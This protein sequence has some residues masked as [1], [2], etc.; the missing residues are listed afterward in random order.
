MLYELESRGLLSG[1]T[2]LIDI[3]KLGLDYVKEDSSGLRI[4]ASTTFTDAL[5]SKQINSRPAF[6]ALV[7]ALSAIRPVQVRNMATL[8]GAISSGLPGLDLPPASV[9]VRAK[10]ALA[11]SRGRRTLDVEDFFLGFLETA[12]K[13]GEFLKE[14][15]VPRPPA[16]TGSAFQKLETNSVDWAILSVATSVTL[17]NDKVS[18]ARIVFGG[19]VVGAV[20]MRATEAE[21]AV[22]DAAATE[23]VIGRA[24]M[25]AEG[26]EIVTIEGIA[27]DGKLDPIQEAMIRH[28][29]IQCGFCT[30]GVIM[31]AKA[32]LASNPRPTEADI[33]EALA[34]N[35]CRCTG[36]VKIIEAVMM[37]AE[38][39]GGRKAR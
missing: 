28:G 17:K 26:K 20:P 39:S 27:R 2:T 34:G 13:R 18:N 19:G 1:V 4:G 25:Q 32:L 5:R 36:Y 30:P 9:A 10:I 23:D 8:G 22:V 3:S 16:H 33:R 15:R 31:S 7:D 12:L 14:V 37:A 24:A 21:E 11:G 38:R 6:G 29:G 35:L